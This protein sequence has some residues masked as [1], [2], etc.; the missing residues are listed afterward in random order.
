MALAGANGCHPDD[1]AQKGLFYR[2]KEK[3]S[4]GTFQSVIAID[5]S[6]PKD[7]KQ[8]GGPLFLEHRG[9]SYLEKIV[10]IA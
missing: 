9:H 6:H 7:E 8:Y 1:D 5:E 10:G 2:L 4:M 3:Q